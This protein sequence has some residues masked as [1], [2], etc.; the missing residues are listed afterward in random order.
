MLAPGFDMFIQLPREDDQRVLNPGTIQEVA[1]GRYTATFN[2]ADLAAEAGQEVIVYFHRG[3]EF[4]QQSARIDAVM[5]TEEQTII[6]FETVGEPVSCESR[7]CFRASTVM[8]GLTARLG[9]ED[10]CQLLDVSATGFAVMAAA[11]HHVGNVL[12]AELHHDGKNYR[13]TATVQS[14]RAMDHDRIRYGLHVVADKNSGGTL[15]KGCQHIAMAVQREQARR[16]SG[17]Q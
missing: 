5:P 8:A 1:D 6:V 2:D 7:Q 4:M 14:V 13:G 11:T 17:T 16:L 3:N 9:D 15:Q 12:E 10:N